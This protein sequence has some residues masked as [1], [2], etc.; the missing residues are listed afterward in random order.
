MET[1]TIQISEDVLARLKPILSKVLVERTQD[2]LRYKE[3][4]ERVERREI[5]TGIE[6]GTYLEWA[7]GRERDADTLIAAMCAMYGEESM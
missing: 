6:A 5:K 3:Y 2:V 7:K 1:V 4:A